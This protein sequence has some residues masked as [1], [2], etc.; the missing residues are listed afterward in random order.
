LALALTNLGL[1]LTASA[2]TRLGPVLKG[3]VSG[4]FGKG[5]DFFMHYIV[6]N[7]ELEI[8][9][10]INSVPRPKIGSGSD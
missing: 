8:N 9:S 3:S 2:P 4:V 10:V 6:F 1:V 5:S 7:A